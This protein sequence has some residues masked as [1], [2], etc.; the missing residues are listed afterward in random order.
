MS[1][2][3]SWRLRGCFFEAND[4]TWQFVAKSAFGSREEMDEFMAFME[5]K[6]ADAKENPEKYEKI[7]E[8]PEQL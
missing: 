7:E 1:F 6:I 8:T 2:P 3:V 4:K 5:E